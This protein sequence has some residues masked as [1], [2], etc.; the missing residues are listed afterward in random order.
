MDGNIGQFW[1]LLTKSTAWGVLGEGGGGGAV[2]EAL[3]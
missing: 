1:C 3:S 2:H